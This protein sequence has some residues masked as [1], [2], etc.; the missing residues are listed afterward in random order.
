MPDLIVTRE[1]EGPVVATPRPGDTSSSI[2]R[3][4][5]AIILLGVL[6]S[7]SLGPERWEPHVV[8]AEYVEG[9]LVASLDPRT[10]SRI[11]VDAG[12]QLEFVSFTLRL[13][14]TRRS[15][16]GGAVLAREAGVPPVPQSALNLTV[17]V[18]ATIQ[19]WEESEPCYDRKDQLLTDWAPVEGGRSVVRPPPHP[20]VV[21]DNWDKVR[22]DVHVRGL[23]DTGPEAGYEI[24]SIMLEPRQIIKRL[25]RNVGHSWH[26]LSTSASAAKKD[27]GG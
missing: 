10:G 24:N 5:V 8:S 11:V 20:W 27:C 18:S 3:R 12:E 26:T 15:S 16:D 19:K 21:G 1:T 6:A 14:P 7:C 17:R 23:P 2:L 9:A 25:K 22:I 4:S 13:L